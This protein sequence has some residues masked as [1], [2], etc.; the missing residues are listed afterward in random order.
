RA[1]GERAGGRRAVAGRGAVARGD[2]RAAASLLGRA[3]GLT[4]PTRVD[5][6]LEMDLADVLPRSEPREAI[7]IADAAA[8]RAR[9]AGTETAEALAR[10]VGGNVRGQADPSASVAELGRPPHAGGPLRAPAGGH[11]RRA[12]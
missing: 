10:V 4:R 7:A 9:E 8:D 6:H 11:A 3:L 5:V 12:D 2:A 1:P